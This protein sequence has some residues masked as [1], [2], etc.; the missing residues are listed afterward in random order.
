MLGSRAIELRSRPCGRVLVERTATNGELDTNLGCVAEFA[1]EADTLHR[2]FF[3]LH[4]AHE[5]LTNNHGQPDETMQFR[6]HHL[7]T[8]EGVRA[9][10]LILVDVFREFPI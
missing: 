2:G 3:L 5:V 6:V 8:L 9:K 10:R 1:E 7:V 4:T